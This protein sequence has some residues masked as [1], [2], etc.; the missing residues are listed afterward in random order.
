MANSPGLWSF[1]LA[2]LLVI[3]VFEVM[4]P[5]TVGLLLDF[6]AKNVLA[7]LVVAL[8]LIVTYFLTRRR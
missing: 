6:V 5:G 3:V 8:I 1:L 4:A 7:I 2:I